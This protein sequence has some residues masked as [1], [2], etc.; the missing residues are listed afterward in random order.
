[1]RQWAGELASSQASGFGCQCSQCPPHPSEEVLPGSPPCRSQPAAASCH[2]Q[3]PGCPSCPIPPPATPPPLLP[4]PRSPHP[5]HVGPPPRVGRLPR[6]TQIHLS[7]SPSHPPPPLPSSA[8]SGPGQT[9]KRPHTT[10][11]LEAVSLYKGNQHYGSISMLLWLTGPTSP[12]LGQQGR[13]GGWATVG[14]EYYTG[15]G[16]ARQGSWE[17]PKS[18]HRQAGTGTKSTTHKGR[19]RRVRIGGWQS[20]PT[21]T[22]QAFSGRQGGRWEGPRSPEARMCHYETT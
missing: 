10:G 21:L 11:R 14:E 6:S 7:S 19:K 20:L 13:G 22:S 17:L 1:M 9:T 8:L 16:T 15:P 12:P 3:A 18:R 2:C 5:G 4:L